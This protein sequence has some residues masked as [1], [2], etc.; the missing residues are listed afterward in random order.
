MEIIKTTPN[1][2]TH[3]NIIKRHT[4][5]N[6]SQ[7]V[8]QIT[9]E[10]KQIVNNHIVLEQVPHP[11][12]TMDVTCAT[13]DSIIRLANVT[14][15]EEINSLSH[16]K[17]D[18]TQGK[19]WVHPDLEGKIL[20]VSYWGMGYELIHASRVYT[21]IN[22]AGDVVESLGNIITRS[23]IALKFLSNLPDAI[24]EG[25]EIVRVITDAR[26]LKEELETVISDGNVLK[27]G[28]TGAIEE[29]TELSNTLETNIIDAFRVNEALSINLD[30]GKDLNVELEDNIA[31]GGELLN[32]TVGVNNT[33]T[34]LIE[35]NRVA[36]D[37]ILP[38]L[39]KFDN[40]KFN[41]FSSD[42]MAITRTIEMPDE[43]MPDEMPEEEIPDEMPDEMPDEEGGTTGGE[44]QRYYQVILPHNLDSTNL[45][46]ACYDSSNKLITPEITIL[47]NNSIKITNLFNIDM[48][49]IINIAYRGKSGDIN[50]GTGNLT[51][52]DIENIKNI[53]TIENKI[54]EI[55]DVDIKNIKNKLASTELLT[56]IKEVDGIGSGLDA[57]FLGGKPSSYFFN[58]I[59]GTLDNTKSIKAKDSLGMS[60]HLLSMASN[61]EIIIGEANYN[62]S[63]F[64]KE[65]PKHFDGENTSSILTGNKADVKAGGFSIGGYTLYIQPDEPPTDV[66]GA[67]WIK[68]I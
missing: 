46:I 5:D 20:T 15:L 22:R 56:S 55:V 36:K 1:F 39:D 16:Y 41:I 64:S 28:L 23:E 45:I 18:Y 59:G 2:R 37:E 7:V 35:A 27:D 52:S 62:T 31:L 54:E 47:D 49:V 34:D 53:P 11:H 25:R 3:T 66:E 30:E 6:G 19:I 40:V 57:E 32:K 61:D 33:L 26:T 13:E 21:E 29:G 8:E 42:W 4:D 43:E 38:E 51:I 58:A 10:Q 63:I 14:Y 65:A 44:T 48:T 17:I 9:K 60:R 12:Y 67:I 68:N 50:G 24:K